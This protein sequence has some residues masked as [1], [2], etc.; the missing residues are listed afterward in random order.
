ML[1]LKKVDAPQSTI[2]YD[3]SK[4]DAQTGNIY[5]AISIIAKRASQINS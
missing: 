5:K 4:I 2:T 3:K 1:Y